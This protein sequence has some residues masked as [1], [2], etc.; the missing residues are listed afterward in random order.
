MTGGRLHEVRRPHMRRGVRIVMV[1][2]ALAALIAPMGYLFSSFWSVTGQ[3]ESEVADERRAVRYLKPLIRLIGALAEAQSRAVDGESVDVAGLRAAMAKVDA[4]DRQHGVAL[5]AQKRWSTLRRQIVAG[6][7]ET[8]GGDQAYRAYGELTTTAL[9]LVAKVGDVSSLATDPEFDAHAA[10]LCVPLVVVHSGQVADLVRSASTPTGG[11]GRAANGSTVAAGRVAVAL[12]RVAAAG[13]TIRE[14][15]RGSEGAVA[16]DGEALAALDEFFAAV[17]ALL[18]VAT[19]ATAGE[20]VAP[21]EV[22]QVGERL[23]SAALLLGD[24]ILT[25]LDSRL[26]TRADGLEDQRIGAAITMAVGLLLGTALLWTSLPGYREPE[27]DPAALP[28][29]GGDLTGPPDAGQDSMDGM[30]PAELVDARELLSNEELLHIGRA[31]RSTRG[32][33]EDGVH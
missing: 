33:P 13:E 12:D 30:V 11:G 27:E 9:A 17:V 32:E 2:V 25:R 18:E 26:E 15:V 21:A 14:G 5:R 19:P 3:S 7:G 22:D 6:F 4:V 28:E 1:F 23:R 20:K 8:T 31:V 10:L 29:T 24:Q 16:E